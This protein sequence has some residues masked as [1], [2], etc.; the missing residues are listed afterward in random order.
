MTLRDYFIA[1][2]FAIAIACM[3]FALILAM[4][5]LLLYRRKNMK[6]IEEKNRE[7]QAEALRADKASAA[8]SN[9]LSSMSHDMRTP[10]NGVIS[11]TSFALKADTLEKKQEYLEKAQQSASILMG[12]I[13][14][15]LEVSRIES[16]KMELQQ[17]WTGFRELIDGITLVIQNLA[18]EK[19]LSFVKEVG[20][21]EDAFAFVDKLKMQDLLMNLLTN[22]VR[23]T[24]EGGAVSLSIMP[25]DPPSEGK[26]VRIRGVGHRRRHFRGVHAEPVRAVCAGVRSPP[27]K[28]RRHRARALYRAQ[29]HHADGRHDHREKPK[30]QG[31]GIYGLPAGQDGKTSKRRA[32]T[33]DSGRP[34][35]FPERKFC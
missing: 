10:L 22:A 34:L 12:L 19:G 3:L 7:L 35:I 17:D 2:P 18:A 14:D 15:T 1:H 27:E 29:N 30:G 9:F 11:F 4:A 26:N 6:L 5:V 31:N 16:G 24:P 23:Y 20:F 28:F 13:N 33:R 8:K 32:F 25:V 21:S